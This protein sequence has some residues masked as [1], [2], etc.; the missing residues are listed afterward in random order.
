M[1]E[2]AVFAKTQEDVVSN[3]RHEKQPA[4]LVQLVR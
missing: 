4:A 3:L 1:G 2:E